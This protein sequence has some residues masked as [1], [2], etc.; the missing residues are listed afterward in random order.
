VRYLPIE[1]DIRGRDALVI[2]AGPEIASKV[3]RLSQAG[4]RI[5]ARAP[6]EVTEADLEG[7]AVVFLAPGDDALGRRLHARALRTGQPFCTLDRPE[8]S[9]FAN[10]AV[11]PLADLTMTFGTSGASPGVA[12]R[13]REDLTALLG[14]ERM[15]RFLA[16]L[17]SLREALPRGGRAARMAKAV[18][19]F[20]IDARLRFPAWFEQDEEP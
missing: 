9:T 3:D 13:I 17:R 11:V 1:L 19:G 2:G 14:D 4:A 15:T 7:K 12:R 20:A 16:R 10:A 6:G 8:T 5:T 18:E